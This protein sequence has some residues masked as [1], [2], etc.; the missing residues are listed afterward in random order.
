MVA[1]GVVVLDPWLQGGGAFVVAGEHVSVG[2]FGLQRPVESFD[3]A[4]LPWAVWTDPDVAGT[5]HRDHLGHGPALRVRPVVVG[6]HFS[7][8]GD[9]RSGEGLGGAGN[10]PGA[11]VCG[12]VGVDLGVRESTVVIDG[13]MHVV[14][15]DSLFGAYSGGVASPC[16]PPTTSGDTPEF[17]DVDMDEV[18]WVVPFIP[19]R[20]GL[21]C[22]DHLTG[23]R[24]TRAKVC[25]VVAAQDP[26]DRACRNTEFVG[27]TIRT[28]PPAQPFG[29]DLLL[30]L[31]GGP[32]R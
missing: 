20:S 21:R 15:S 14:V 24:V 17:L 22:A 2:P 31:E 12:L 29:K 4:V 9:A 23:E 25:D 6:H 1:S 5:E 32:R 30:N 10:E 11:G 16:P 18:T 26:T 7:D 3:F 19:H 13:R 8:P 28:N 27:E